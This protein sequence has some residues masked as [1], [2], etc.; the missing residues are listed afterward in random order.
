MA[1]VSSNSFEESFDDTAILKGYLQLDACCN[2][3]VM[4]QLPSSDTA[5]ESF[6]SYPGTSH[7]E[8]VHRS[9][10]DQGRDQ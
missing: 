10:A 2:K 8:W 9:A 6:D 1:L 7:K 5:S 3:I 4:T